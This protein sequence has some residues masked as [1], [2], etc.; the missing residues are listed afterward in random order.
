MVERIVPVALVLGAALADHVGAHTLAFDALLVAIPVTAVAG[1]Q[2]VSDRLEGKARQAQ[3]YVWAL[4]LGLLLVATAVRAP[5]VG[6]PS[7]PALAR[8]A[9]TACVIVFC[10]QACAA[11]AWEL[12]TGSDK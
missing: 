6:D 8:S 12:R 10:L 2:T 5:A 9:L 1:L 11:L 4:V 7:V 3:A